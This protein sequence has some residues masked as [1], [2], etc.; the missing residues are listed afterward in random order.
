MA[1]QADD[2]TFPSLLAH[3]MRGTAACIGARG[4]AERAKS[5]E[6]ACER[7]ATDAE[8]EALLDEAVCALQP[9][10]REL[11]DLELDAAA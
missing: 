7:S 11:A 1:C 4:L 8:R 3:N 10:L 2:A 6:L 9:V 5:L